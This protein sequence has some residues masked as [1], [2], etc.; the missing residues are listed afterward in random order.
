MGRVADPKIEGQTAKGALAL[1]LRLHAQV[2]SQ[3]IQY[4]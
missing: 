4:F 2:T 1:P 3:A